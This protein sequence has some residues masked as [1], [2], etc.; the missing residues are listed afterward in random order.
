MFALCHKLDRGA[1]LPGGMMSEDFGV[2]ITCFPGDAYFAQASYLSVRQFLGPDIPIC[3]IVDG[4]PQCLGRVLQDPKV[5]TLTHTAV[6]DSRLRDTGFGWGFTKM[7]GFWHSPFTE[8]LCLDADAL[9]WGN[10]IQNYYKPSYDFIIDQQRSYTDE[11]IDF[12][13][14]STKNIQKHYAHFDYKL[15]RDRYAC[16]GTFFMR[17]GAIP[18]DEWYEAAMLQKN[19]QGIFPFGGEMGPLNF[20]WA[21]G[22]QRETLKIRS[23]TYQII[24]VDHSDAELRRYY[25]PE[26]LESGDIKPAVLHFCGKKP[27][28]FSHSPKVAVMNYFRR[29]YLMEID[30]LSAVQAT[31][32]MGIQ[33]FRF[34]LIPWLK[35]GV[36]KLKKYCRTLLFPV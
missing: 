31:L 27:H 24:P 11:E 26:A 32:L 2:V 36:H 17:R 29:R 30:R 4:D 28:I 3:F 14:F 23:V 22:A 8:S 5:Q 10:V 25:S 6:T 13:F 33:D 7:V 20:L 15:F 19:T 1:R 35:R 16:T 12:W 34:V 9:V 18:L 21:Y